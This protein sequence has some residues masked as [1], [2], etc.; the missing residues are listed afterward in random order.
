M[1]LYLLSSPHLRISYTTALVCLVPRLPVSTKESQAHPD[2][3]HHLS[4]LSNSA[5][6]LDICFCIRGKSSNAIV[7]LGRGVG[8][9]T[10]V[11]GSSIVRI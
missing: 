11:E 4:T 8:A 2:N 1:S 6:A 7:I 3:S 5:L 10:Y 9:D